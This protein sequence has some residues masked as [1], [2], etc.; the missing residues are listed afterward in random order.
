MRPSD[1]GPTKVFRLGPS[2]AVERK[3]LL[4]AVLL[5]AAPFVAAYIQWLAFGLPEIG[6]SEIGSSDPSLPH[7][8]PAWA[9]LAHYL[10]FL[11]MVLIIRSGL[12]ILMSHPR[13]YWNVH[14]TPGSEWLRLTPVAEL[15]RDRLWTANDD[16]RHL[17]PWIGLPGYRFSVGM[18]RHW[19]FLSALFW[20]ING[21][22]FVALLFS[23]SH[24]RRLVPSSWQVIP[25]AWSVF[26][27]YATLHLPPEPDGFY[28][29]NA[30]QQ[31]SYFAAVFVLAP[32]SIITG[33]SMSPALTARFTWYPRLPG[34]RQVGRS[35][36]F[37]LL[38]AFLAFI[39]AHVSMVV[40][41]GLTRNMNH[42]VVGTDDGMPRGLYLGLVG[43]AVIVAVNALANWA[44]WRRPRT[45]Q[46]LAKAIITPLTWFM[47]NRVEPRA[48]F[49]REDISPYLWPNGKLPTSQH[50]QDLAANGFKDYRLK[51]GGLV[52]NPVELSLD[53]LRA[54][55]TSTQITLH[56]CI[57]GWSGIAEWRGVPMSRILDLVRPQANATTAFF[58]SFGEGPE[59]GQFYDSHS[60]ENLR[61]SQTLLAFDMNGEPLGELHGAPLRL[62][63]ENQLGFKMVK[64]IESIEFV[65]SIK[66]VYQGEGGY[67]EDHE[68]FGE[69]ANI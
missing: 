53:E 50:Y 26:V 67:K 27:H 40:L 63:V 31:L 42:I 3:T 10:N 9:R 60:L 16:A 39:V 69:L 28:R 4:V 25:D 65:D 34:N 21:L 66:S 13:L 47:L 7:G 35:I 15:P 11:F 19:H 20:V 30:L 51:I 62:R 8:F 32:L 56:H 36:H 33:P 55:G 6:E 44:A 49:R 5:V 2:F 23:S 59:G 41:T 18:A 12:Q 48:Q 17:S 1:S 43:I 24:W 29:Y 22:I 64:W 46:H 52:E 38:C 57:Q 37:L 61:H 14:C 54:M 45:V 58:H 68:Y